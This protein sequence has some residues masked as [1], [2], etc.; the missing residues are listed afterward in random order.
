MF[1]SRMILSQ[2]VQFINSTTESVDKQRPSIGI[3]T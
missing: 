3:E 1:K 2:G